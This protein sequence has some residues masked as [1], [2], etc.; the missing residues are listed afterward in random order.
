VIPG[1]L[2]FVVAALVAAPVAALVASNVV[3]SGKD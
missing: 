3:E 1:G 2:L